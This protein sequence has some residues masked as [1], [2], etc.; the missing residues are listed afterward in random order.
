MHT[1]RDTEKN[2]R[3]NSGSSFLLLLE[4]SFPDLQSPANKFCSLT[5]CGREEY[6]FL[7]GIFQTSP[8]YS[9]ILQQLL[10]THTEH[11]CVCVKPVCMCL[12]SY[13][14]VQKKGSRCS[15]E[16]KHRQ[17][18]SSHQS[19]PVL[20]FSSLM[21]LTAVQ[22]IGVSPVDHFTLSAPRSLLPR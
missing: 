21:P 7:Q 1:R 2:E 13:H 3:K 22:V 8:L 10:H 12:P 11:A 16:I 4:S 9:C 19:S 5:Q 17:Y 20:L 6:L 18:F 15:Q 14:E